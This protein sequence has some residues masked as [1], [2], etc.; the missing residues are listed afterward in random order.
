[1]KMMMVSA[2]AMADAFA[3]VADGAPPPP[4][5]LGFALGD[6]ADAAVAKSRATT[7]RKTSR[8]SRRASPASR[9]GR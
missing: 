6:R 4:M 9:R 1:M 5:F 8:R 2:C 7:G 3:A